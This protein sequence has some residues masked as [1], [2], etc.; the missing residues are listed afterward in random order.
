MIDSVADEK[1]GIRYSD[2]MNKHLNKLAGADTGVNCY[3]ENFPAGEEEEEEEEEGDEI[4]VFDAD[5]M[6]KLNGQVNAALN[7]Y[8]RHNA[9][10][11]RGKV[12]RQIIRSA[13]KTKKFFNEKNNC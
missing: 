6:C 8:T 7:S 11:G 1:W 5:D 4:T 2:R 3:D 13:R 9:C 10:Q 12:Y